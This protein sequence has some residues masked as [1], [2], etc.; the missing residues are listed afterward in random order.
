MGNFAF[1]DSLSDRKKYKRILRIKITMKMLRYY[2]KTEKI[3]YKNLKK[4]EIFY[5]ICIF[6]KHW[7]NYINRN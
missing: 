1:I 7:H 6:Q 4:N 3:N 5:Y 2:K